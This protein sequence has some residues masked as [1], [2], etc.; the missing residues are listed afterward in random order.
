MKLYCDDCGKELE[1]SV[2]EAFN[3]SPHNL[4]N[5][6]VEHIKAI[7]DDCYKPEEWEDLRN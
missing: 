1:G 2:N 4:M 6:K 3:E 5:V 7:C